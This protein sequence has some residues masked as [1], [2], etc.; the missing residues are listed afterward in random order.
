MPQSNGVDLSKLT[1]G[2]ISTRDY[3][4]MLKGNRLSKWYY[5]NCPIEKKLSTHIDERIFTSNISKEFINTLDA[6]GLL[7]GVY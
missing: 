5:P 4:D 2:A 6:Y 1:R 7:R 3:I